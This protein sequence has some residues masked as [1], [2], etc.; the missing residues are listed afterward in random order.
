MADTIVKYRFDLGELELASGSHNLI[1]TNATTSLTIVD[2]KVNLNDGFVTN[3]DANTDGFDI[4]SFTESVSGIE[5]LPPSTT[6]Q[7]T[8]SGTYPGSYTKSEVAYVGSNGLP[9]FTTGLTLNGRPLNVLS[10]LEKTAIATAYTSVS[11]NPKVYKKGASYYLIYHDGNSYAG[12]V[13]WA[14]INATPVDTSFTNYVIPATDDLSD[15]VYWVEKDVSYGRVANGFYK[16]TPAGGIERVG[17]NLAAHGYAQSTYC[18]SAACNGYYFY[19]PTTSFTTQVYCIDMTIG[20]EYNLS[21]TV[22]SSSSWNG[23]RL[24]VSYCTD[25]SSFWIGRL[26]NSEHGV[27]GLI[28]EATLAAAGHGAGGNYSATSGPYSV[29]GFSSWTTTGL[30]YNGKK[31]K[32]NLTHGYCDIVGPETSGS[33]H[34][35]HFIDGENADHSEIVR[36]QLSQ[37]SFYR[38]GNTGVDMSTGFNTKQVRFTLAI[39]ETAANVAANFTYSNDPTISLLITAVESTEG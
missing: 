26:K 2:V 28:T 27:Y 6:L 23:M 31:L 1:T 35:V 12:F 16:H 38:Q 3:L 37:F 9:T 8:H 39:S 11:W 21:S 22:M 32:Y 15:G 24:V 36:G 10:P 18:R 19:I 34:Y 17:T 7:V 33:L 5:H 29:A 14:D 4:G 25:N 13:Y 30:V 20:K